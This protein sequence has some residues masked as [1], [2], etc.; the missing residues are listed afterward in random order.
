MRRRKLVTVKELNL[1]SGCVVQRGNEMRVFWNL[2]PTLGKSFAHVLLV[3]QLG[4]QTSVG[5]TRVTTAGSAVQTGFQ[6]IVFHFAAV[7]T[8]HH[9][10]RKII[11]NA[12]SS[13]D[14]FS[15]FS[16]LLLVNPLFGQRLQRR[17]QPLVMVLRDA[18]ELRL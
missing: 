17:S 8:E 4:G 7:P 14:S 10:S 15:K 9:Q 6:W 11:N 18:V 5:L 16:L 2:N 1:V 3:E 12:N 13:Q